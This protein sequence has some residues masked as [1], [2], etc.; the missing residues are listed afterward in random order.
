MMHGSKRLA[1]YDVY[2]SCHVTKHE[3]GGGMV[4]NKR[5]RP[6]VSG[7]TPVNERIAITH[8]RTEFYNIRLICAQ[9]PTDEK[10]DVVL[11]MSS[12]LNSRTYMISAR[13][14]MQ[15]SSSEILIRRSGR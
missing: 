4:V 7:F 15:K 9:A 1:S 11:K 14:M 3:F 5:L 10:D 8:I 13:P 12:T 2:Y 6:L